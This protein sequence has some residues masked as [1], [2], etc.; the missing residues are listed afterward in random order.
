MIENNS[1]RPEGKRRRGIFFPLL[2]LA[3]GILLLL[4]NFGYLP[5]GFWGFVSTYWPVLLILAGLDGL[6]KG[7]GVTG[8]ILFAG[9]GAVLLAGNLGTISLTTWDLISKAWPLVLIG[10]GLDIIIGRRTLGRVLLGLALAVL[11]VFGLVWVSNFSGP[12]GLNVTEF[13]QKYQNESNLTFNIQRTAGTVQVSS[14]APSDSII[15]GKIT[16]LR[17]EKMT[18]IVEHSSA[19]TLIEVKN[20][21]STFPGTSRP[22]EN[23]AWQFAINQKPALTL[24]SKV[25]MGENQIDTRGLNLE[26]MKVE[27]VT[28]QTVVT[29]ADIPGAQA[30]ISGAIGEIVVFIPIGA[31]VR[32]QANKAIGGLSIPEGYVRNGNDIF[33]PAYQAGKPAV[34]L[35]VDLPIGAIRLVEYSTK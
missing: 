4:S 34:E 16:L 13:N 25:I 19:T 33:S 21:T 8:S 17:N 5:G 15:Q 32:V 31:A 2:L 20:D 24:S 23:S 22:Y 11:L 35:K 27:T 9:F 7:D 6:V 26:K 10:I 1:D 14:G 28:G 12:R 29:L 18:P 30:Q 3:A